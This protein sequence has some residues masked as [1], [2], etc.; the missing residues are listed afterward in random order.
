M[1]KDDK[2]FVGFFIKLLHLAVITD[3][4]EAY[5]LG[6]RNYLIH[7]HNMMDRSLVK[8]EEGQI[9]VC[10]KVKRV[11]RH[12]QGLPPP[13]CIVVHLSILIV[14]EIFAYLTRS[15]SNETCSALEESASIR[16]SSA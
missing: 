16:M 10:L 3:E 5:R 12:S 15:K 13:I 9:E 4:L 7:F 6:Q 8:G 2:S 14:R 11:G 1:R